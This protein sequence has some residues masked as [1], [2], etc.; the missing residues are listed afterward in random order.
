MGWSDDPKDP[1][2]NTCVNL[3]YAFSHEKL[4]RDDDLYDLFITIDHNTYHYCQ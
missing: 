4:W 2:Y 3:P 1:S